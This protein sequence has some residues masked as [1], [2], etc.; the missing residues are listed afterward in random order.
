M[1]EASGG[2]ARL[3]GAFGQNAAVLGVDQALRFAKGVI[4]ARLLSPEH[5]GVFGI[6]LAISSGLAVFS[7]LGLKSCFISATVDGSESTR[8]WLETIWTIEI[9]RGLTLGAALLSC[10]GWLSE[11]FDT[12]GLFPVLLV[13]ATTPVLNGLANPGMFLLEKQI[14][15]RPVARRDLWATVSGFLATVLLA[16]VV[17]SALALALGLVVQALLSVVLSYRLSGFRPHLSLDRGVVRQCLS[18]GKH[19]FV[20]GV[21][22]YVTTQVDNL[23]VGKLLGSEQLG[24]YLVAY[25]LAMLPVMLLGQVVTRVVLPYY[26]EAWT[27]GGPQAAYQ[28]WGTTT[29]LTSWLV[30]GVTLCLW[31]ARDWLI[32]SIYGSQWRPAVTVF[33]ILVFAGLLRGLTHTISPMLLAARRPGVDALVKT[34]EAS[35]FVLLLAFLIP[36]YGLIGAG[37]AG[38]SSYG[39]AFVGRFFFILHSARDQA[40]AVAG[41]YLQIAVSLAVS[42]IVSGILGVGFHPLMQAG[43]ALGVFFML[44]LLLNRVV[45]VEFIHAVRWLAP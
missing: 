34:V 35:V 23:F 39:A 33:G 45:R 1:N 5:F 44:A 29:S 31:V 38:V 36:R 19:L 24:F 27:R 14:Q 21:L 25:S 7:S 28:R 43:C 41:G 40:A 11:F 22:T 12:P 10:S 13:V 30:C 15:F 37:L 3:Y 17:R 6:A 9:L 26:S 32:P 4:L 8:K 42:L 16:W 18:F 2:R 20:V